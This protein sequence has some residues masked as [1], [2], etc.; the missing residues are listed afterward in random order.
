[1]PTSTTGI[2]SL[3]LMTSMGSRGEF[4][5]E[6]PRRSVCFTRERSAIHATSCR[7]LPCWDLDLEGVL[8]SFVRVSL[9]LSTCCVWFLR[10]PFCF[11][12]LQESQTTTHHFSGFPIRVESTPL[13]GI[14]VH[15]TL[16]TSPAERCGP[17]VRGT[18]KDSLKASDWL[19]GFPSNG[20]FNSRVPYRPTRGSTTLRNS[21]IR[22]CV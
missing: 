21:Q 9:S 7:T 3:R 17:A 2:P 10:S 20:P 11:V 1:M 19:M 13:T 12:C 16:G 22:G 14:A 8:G 18:L 4:A 15:P 6:K 5:M